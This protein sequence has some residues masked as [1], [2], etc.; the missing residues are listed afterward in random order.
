MESSTLLLR[1]KTHN[2]NPSALRTY[3][4]IFREEFDYKWPSLLDDKEN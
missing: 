4:S 2:N 1:Y 3:T